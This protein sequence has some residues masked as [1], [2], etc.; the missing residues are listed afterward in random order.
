MRKAV[1]EQL[2]RG[3]DYIKIMSTG[4][5]SVVLED[6]EPAQMTRAEA[7]AVV[8]EVHRMGKRVASHTEGLEGA[9]LGIRAGVDTVEHGL[10]LHRDPALL[11]TMAERGIVLVPTLTTF[12]DVAEIHADLYPPVLVE[13]ARRQREEA[14]QTLLAARD[15]GVTLAM[16]YD[17]TP[18]GTNVRELI[19]MVEGGLTAM[20]GLVA[21]TS[22]SA[23]ALGRGDL[24]R[25]AQGAVADLIAIDG[26]PLAD[27]RQLARPERIWLV[28]Q[29]GEAVAGSILDA[30]DP[31]TAL[32]ISEGA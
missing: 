12:H 21:A 22:G 5:R 2:S 13:Q 10:S 27:I 3:A 9:R 23:A 24:G 15:A 8:D 7:E 31:S 18:H 14:Y 11:E 20:Q 28:L 6:P 19:R 25:I 16:G 29:A 32:Q 4:A 26:D 30:P 17:S 1:R